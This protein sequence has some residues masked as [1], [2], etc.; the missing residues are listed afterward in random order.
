VEPMKLE[1]FQYT[2]TYRSPA[3]TG[4]GMGFAYWV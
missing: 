1:F 4:C 2:T 3:A